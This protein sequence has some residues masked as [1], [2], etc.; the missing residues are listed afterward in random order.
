MLKCFFMASG[1][2]INIHTSKLMGIGVPHEEVI[3]AANLIAMYGDCGSIDNPTFFS[4]TSPWSDIIKEVA[5]LSLKGVIEEEQH[6][7]LVEKAT[8]LIL[9]NNAHRWSCSLASLGEFSV[10]TARSHI[11]DILLLLVGTATRWVPVI[12][13]KINV[14][15]WK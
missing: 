10:K 4:R 14:F 13:I 15:A 6:L 12:P 5:G 3:S 2:K 1:L 11:D 8:S 9:S 7:N